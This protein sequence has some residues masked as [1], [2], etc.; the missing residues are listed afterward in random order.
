MTYGDSIRGPSYLRPIRRILNKGKGE[1]VRWVEERT[2]GAKLGLGSSSA[3]SLRSSSSLGTRPKPEEGRSVKRREPP[4]DRSRLYLALRGGFIV[5]TYGIIR[6]SSVPH[7][8]PEPLVSPS[9]QLRQKQKR[10]DAIGNIN[11]R[12]I[13]QEG[14]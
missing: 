13:L 8:A 5:V 12:P 10:A 7:N 6:G 1:G 9:S 2:L 14:P 11:M 4:A 3:L